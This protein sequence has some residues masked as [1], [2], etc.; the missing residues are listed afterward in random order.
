METVLPR[1]SRLGSTN[2]PLKGAQYEAGLRSI[3]CDH[4]RG[5]TF[6]DTSIQEHDIA[7]SAGMP[8][9]ARQLSG[10]PPFTL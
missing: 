3:D 4:Q 6:L 7:M 9:A 10:L 1:I 2:A 5:Q 8:A